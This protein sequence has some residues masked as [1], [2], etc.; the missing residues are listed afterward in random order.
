[1]FLDGAIARL[2]PDLDILG[3]VAN[4]SMIFAEKHGD[5]LAKELG[6]APDSVEFDPDGVRASLGLTA[7]VDRITYRELQARRELIQKRMRDH[8]EASKV[9]G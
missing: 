7:D 9:G 4:I 1:V 8:V 2:A 6:V 3:E 5:R